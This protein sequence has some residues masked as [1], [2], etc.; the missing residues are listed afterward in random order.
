MDKV[1]KW[2]LNEED[3]EYYYEDSPENKGSQK[4]KGII[5]VKTVYID[6]IEKMSIAG[7]AMKEGKIVICKISENLLIRALDF[8]SGVQYA[9]A[10]KELK[11]TENDYAF[12][13]KN[14]V[15]DETNYVKQNQ[16]TEQ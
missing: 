8:L 11:I 13:P 14:V 3:D 6:K 9:L 16:N 4:P 12:I 5:D 2:L 1:K 10:Y 7:T 15:L